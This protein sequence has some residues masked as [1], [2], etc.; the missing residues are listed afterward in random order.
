[1][2]VRTG[3]GETRRLQALDARTPFSSV[4]G[5]VRGEES[6]GGSGGRGTRGWLTDFEVLDE[7]DNGDG[8][9]CCLCSIYNVL[10]WGGGGFRS[11]IVCVCVCYVCVCP[12]VFA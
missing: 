4:A 11:A 8:E 6:G 7:G 9:V 5:L 12:H 2:E 1:M 3:S 10:L